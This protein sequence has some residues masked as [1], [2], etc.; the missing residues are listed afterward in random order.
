MT[1]KRDRLWFEMFKEKLDDFWSMVVRER[2]TIRNIG[3]EEYQRLN[4]LLPKDKTNPGHVCIEKMNSCAL[5]EEDEINHPQRGPPETTLID[6]MVTTPV[7]PD[8]CL[9]IDID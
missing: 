7:K 5:L 9:L 4:G 3:V 8:E 6:F 1:V 2:D